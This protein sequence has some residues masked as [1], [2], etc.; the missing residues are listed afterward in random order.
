M[1]EWLLFSAKPYTP[2]LAASACLCSG[3]VPL[4]SPLPLPPPTPAQA[5][6]PGGNSEP[7]CARVPF[8]SPHSQSPE[9]R[10]SSLDPS[11]PFFL[12]L[13]L[14][15][16]HFLSLSTVQGQGAVECLVWKM[17]P[18]LPHTHSPW[19]SSTPGGSS[20]VGER[21]APLL[22]RLALL[23][24]IMSSSTF[25]YTHQSAWVPFYKVPIHVSCPF[26]Y[27]VSSFFFSL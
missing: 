22:S 8:P 14:L 25:S 11:L 15:P 26:F 18:I 6:H 21:R 17:I 1:V 23:W 19:L 3:V 2:C 12:P 27:W 13:S 16:A 5:L 10:M 7:S 9:S 4:G 20:L 24:L